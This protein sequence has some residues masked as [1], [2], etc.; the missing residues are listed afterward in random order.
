MRKG[1]RK[2][3]NQNREVIWFDPPNSKQ[4]S[5]NIDKR[6]RNLLYQHF[7][8]KERLN[9]TLI[10]MMLMLVTHTHEIFPVF[11]YLTIKNY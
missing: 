5:A 6:F 2:N 4:I 10:E 1:H 8:K 9:R 11:F 7:P 3:N